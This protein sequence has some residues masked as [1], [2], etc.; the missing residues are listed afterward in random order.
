MRNHLPRWKCLLKILIIIL[1]CLGVWMWREWLLKAPKFP[2][3]QRRV[4]R[5]EHWTYDIPRQSTIADHAATFQWQSTPLGVETLRI[6]VEYARHRLLDL[7]KA[8]V[9]RL[10]KF[11]MQLGRIERDL[12]QL[13]RGRDPYRNRKGILLRAY[14][15]DI[16]D[17]LQPFSL[18]IPRNYNGKRPFPLIVHLHAHGWFRPFQGH[19]APRLAGAIVLSP[20]GRGSTDYM[21]IGEKDVLQAIEVTKRLYTIDDDRVYLVGQSMGGTGCWHLAVHHP[22]LFAAIAPTCGNTDHT[23]W[24]K[25]WGWGKHL[26]PMISLRRQLEDALDPITY[27]EN[28]KDVPVYCAHG[29]QDTIV[30]V[31]HSRNMVRRLKELGCPVKYVE[32]PD[33]EHGDFPEWL[34]K[35]QIAWL[36]KHRRAE[37]PS[38]AKKTV[39]DVLP[40]RR[41][42]TPP[43]PG[44]VEDAFQSRFLVVLGTS[45]GSSMDNLVVQ[46]EA[47]QFAREWKRR[48]GHPCR[49]KSDRDVTEADMAESNL[50]LYGNPSQNS[51]TARFEDA[52]PIKIANNR[53]I[54]NWV[55]GTGAAVMATTQE[56]VG[57]D[58]GT[59][60][61]FP[62]PEHPTK[63]ILVFAG[64]TW[65]GLFQINHRFGN[66]F[67]WGVYDNR[68]WYDYAIFDDKSVDPDG[69]LMAGFF[70]A[71]WQFCAAPSFAAY[72]PIRRVVV[73]R[74]APTYLEPPAD[75]RSFALSDLMP[76]LIDQ[77]K[78][79][80]E[81][82]RSF[83][84][85][86]LHVGSREFSKGLGVRAPSRIVYETKGNWK[87]FHA[88]VG[89]GSEGEVVS[90]ARRDVEMV[91]F[92]VVGD[93]KVLAESP[94][95][96]WSSQPYAFDI[97]IAGVRR[98]ELITEPKDWHLWLFGSAAW[99]D[100]EVSK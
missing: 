60:F 22:E 53:I 88:V 30:P 55:C 63:Y 95:I 99:G 38:P 92:K 11:Q 10:Q 98:L 16:D 72:D 62:N 83:Q 82:N 76:L 54:V 59:K 14:W 90:Q 1:V 49:V 79:T 73:P 94:E 2:A 61:C 42:R 64:T 70:D 27:A 3:C 4:A 77:Q 37:N 80:V 28:L 35:D 26:S 41:N 13:K 21:F 97:S 87:R 51:V 65:R 46:R 7:K 52:L 8:D 96:D 5:L 34:L 47:R 78:G 25:K 74:Q 24:E 33:V 19:P 71:N 86:R 6:Q 69:F 43:L 39:G 58:V 75:R 36:L 32:F 84:A 23:V 18:V 40:W 44:P 68:N 57:D 29:A 91:Q 100:V 20:Q 66:W 12:R 67:D 9:L 15:S 89:L 17:T 85:H 48:Y 50:V 81:L 45:S 93:G 31:E 56:Y